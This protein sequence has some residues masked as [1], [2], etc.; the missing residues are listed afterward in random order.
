MLV[1]AQASCKKYP[2]SGCYIHSCQLCF[3]LPT[4]CQDL[5]P[6]TCQDF[7]FLSMPPG[8]SL[9]PEEDRRERSRSPYQSQSPSE[10]PFQSGQTGGGETPIPNPEGEAGNIPSTP[11]APSPRPGE[12]FIIQRGSHP[13]DPNLTSARRVIGYHPDGTLILSSI[14]IYFFVTRWSRDGA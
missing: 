11:P 7:F 4:T 10:P 6:T 2:Y 9:T 1:S 3:L 14:I 13:F 5:P 12:V 8:R